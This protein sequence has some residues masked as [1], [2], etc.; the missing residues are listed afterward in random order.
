[1]KNILRYAKYTI[2]SAVLGITLSLIFAT[3]INLFIPG[4]PETFF[5]GP[6]FGVIIYMHLENKFKANNKEINQK[7]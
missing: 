5:T 2:I 7:I 4:F 3:I 6:I 1:M